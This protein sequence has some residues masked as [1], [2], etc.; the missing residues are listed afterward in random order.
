MLDRLFK[1]VENKEYN[2]ADF[3]IANRENKFLR[4][5]ILKIYT[6]DKAFIKITKSWCIEGGLF[7]GQRVDYYRI[8]FFVPDEENSI[9]TKIIKSNE[10]KELYFKIQNLFFDVKENIKKD[11]INKY[12]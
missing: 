4:E 2:H 12:F 10:D 3:Y 11:A 1:I 5:D 6:K 7:R 8:S 9:Y